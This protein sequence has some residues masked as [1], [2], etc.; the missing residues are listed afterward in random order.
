MIF[1]EIFLSFRLSEC[2]LAVQ[3]R[4]LFRTLTY[5]GHVGSD[6][7]MGMR[8]IGKKRKVSISQVNKIMHYDVIINNIKGLN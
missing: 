6:G 2:I 7:V 8:S 3:A 5:L 1:D 4:Q